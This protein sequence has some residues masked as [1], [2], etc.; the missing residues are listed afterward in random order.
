MDT[1][2]RGKFGSWLRIP[3]KKWGNIF[4]LYVRYLGMFPLCVAR[5]TVHVNLKNS[6]LCAHA[7]EHM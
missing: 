5:D 2:H 1:A 3:T 4:K 7:T 6:R